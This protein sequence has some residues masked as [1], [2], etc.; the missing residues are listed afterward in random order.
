[1]TDPTKDIDALR[2]L[3]AAQSRFGFHSALTALVAER[4]KLVEDNASQT[5]KGNSVRYWHDKASAYK[6][7]I[8]SLWEILE[9]AAVR[10]PVD[11][12]IADALTALVAERNKAKADFSDAWRARCEFAKRIDEADAAL[13]AANQ[14]IKE[15][16]SQT[17]ES[18]QRVS[19]LI[20]EK[21]R[22]LDRI[23]E[24]EAQPPAG[25]DLRERLVCAIWPQ[26]LHQ[27]RASTTPLDPFNDAR[28]DAVIEADKMIAEMRKVV[29]REGHR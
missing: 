4:D 8:G 10:S 17:T 7:T 21:W 22:L 13:A 27:Y 6:A 19:D 3:L 20:A 12:T 23:K 11:Q 18:F 14:R 9:S 25:S 24:L 16:E 2:D 29:E 28:E 1:M 15:L 5:Y 26:I